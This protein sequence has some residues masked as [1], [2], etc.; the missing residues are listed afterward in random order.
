VYEGIRS[1]AIHMPKTVGDL[2]SAVTRFP[3]ATFWAGGTYIMSRHDYYPTR[4]SNDII[5]LAEI[6]D[7]KRINRTDRFIEVG[8]M[9]T[10]SQLIAVGKQVLPDLLLK[11]LLTMG[12]RI[13]RK[14]MTVGG[15]LCTPDIRLG[16]P[17]TL[18]VLNSEV[19]IKK[20]DGIRTENRWIPVSRL[21][22]RSGILLLENNELVTRIRIG[23][24]QEGF[25]TFI[26]AG[27]PLY[28]PEETVLFSL[29]CSYNQ[30]TI[31][32]FRF[33]FTLPRSGFHMSHEMEMLI[34]G[35]LLPLTPNQITRFTRTLMTEIEN[36]HT[37]AT[38]IQ[39]ERI[40]RF[41]E[42]SFHEL[43]SRSLS[44]H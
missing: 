34:R 27:N 23:F 28:N 6:P 42:A 9:V 24:E 5:S 12:T 10:I 32:G 43:N 11:T 21:Y 30:S 29:V 40:R 17:G 31:N 22:D 38:G 36:T 18:S 41:F 20:C 33:C 14:Q 35:M 37:M 4:N 3:N 25:S 16:L 19:E 8:S 1:P 44:D 15:A 2:V 7:F 26:F 13:L 39:K